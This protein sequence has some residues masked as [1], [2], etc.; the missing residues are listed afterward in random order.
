MLKAVREAKEQTTWVANNKDFEDAL[1]LF[2]ERTLGHEPFLKELEQFV[3]KVKG[4]G[5][6][7]SLAQTLIKHTA[8]GVPDL[9]QGTELW[10]LSLVDPDN[11]RSVDYEIRRRLLE[12]LKAM[13]CERCRC[14][15]DGKDARRGYPRCG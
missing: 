6:V 11:R 9:Y 14:A 13:K 12:E 3:E 1:F 2:I 15:G 8:P 10:D 5:R 4:P 7:N